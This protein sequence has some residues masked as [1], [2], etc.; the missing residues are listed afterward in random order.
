MN[1]TDQF[2]GRGKVAA[3]LR[4]TALGLRTLFD[5][6]HYLAFHVRDTIRREV[7]ILCLPWRG[8]LRS[9]VLWLVSDWLGI[10]K[11]YQLT[12]YFS[13]VT[14]YLRSQEMTENGAGNSAMSE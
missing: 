7:S 11:F 8:S 12:D 2:R 3:G 6:N 10:G 9:R 1:Q 5:Y 4:W 14:G 13:T